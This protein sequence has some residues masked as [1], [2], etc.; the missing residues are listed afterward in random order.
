MLTCM[1][2]CC[3]RWEEAACDPNTQWAATNSTSR[4]YPSAIE[5][6]TQIVKCIW[7]FIILIICNSSLHKVVNSFSASSTDVLF[8]PYWSTLGL[9]LLRKFFAFISDWIFL[10]IL[11]N[12]TLFFHI[13]IL[14]VQFLRIER[15]FSSIKTLNIKAKHEYLIMCH[16]VIMNV[17]S[18]K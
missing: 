12:F 3:P 16:K 8:F 10:V 5:V 15:W 13:E 1:L 18:N 17:Q 9:Y 4:G 7:Y 6:F 14:N 2:A 11:Y